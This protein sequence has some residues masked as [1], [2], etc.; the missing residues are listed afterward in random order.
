MSLDFRLVFSFALLQ[1]FV[2]SAT[3]RKQTA[4]LSK[5]LSV[6]SDNGIPTLSKM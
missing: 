3:A 4:I 2:M 1:S 6:L 5:L